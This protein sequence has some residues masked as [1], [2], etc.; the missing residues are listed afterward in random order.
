MPLYKQDHTLAMPTPVHAQTSAAKKAVESMIAL[1]HAR[2]I[3]KENASIVRDHGRP[4]VEPY[5]RAIKAEATFCRIRITKKGKVKDLGEDFLLYD[6][7]DV[8][9]LDPVT[10][11]ARRLLADAEKRGW[12]TNLVTLADRCSVEGVRGTEAF[13][14]VWVRGAADGGYWHERDYRYEYVEDTRPEPRLNQKLK[15]SLANRRPVGV[16]KTHLKI[17]GSP[18]GISIGITAL[19]KKVKES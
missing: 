1:G 9:L 7:T 13:R 4:K 19:V 5:V 17:V 16:S 11:A 12:K 10:A 2:R 8:E 15:V 6:T 18:M 3:E 14:A